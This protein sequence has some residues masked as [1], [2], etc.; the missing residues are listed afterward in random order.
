LAGGVSSAALASASPPAP[1]PVAHAG[2]PGRD[3]DVV[4]RGNDVGSERDGLVGVR[5]S[6]A[7]A[8]LISGVIADG[9]GATGTGTGGDGD[10]DGR[11][12]AAATGISNPS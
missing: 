4:V 5:F 10:G 3:D 7:S 6:A 8:A 1:S 11:A 9:A 12:G 2:N